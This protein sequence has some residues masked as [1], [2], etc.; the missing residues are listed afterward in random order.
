MSERPA[1]DATSGTSRTDEIRHI[2]ARLFYE[3]GYDAVGMRMI[4]EAAGVRPASLYHHFRSKEAMLHEIALEVTRD[5]ID[6]HLEILAS[7]DDYPGRLGRLVEL[8]VLYFWRHRYAM[9][10]G[11]REMR[12]LAPDH[13]AE[14]H[15]MRLRYQHAI[16]EFI[17]AG[18]ARGDFDC[19]DPHLAALSLLDMVNGINGWFRDSGRLTIAEVASWYADM[20]VGRLLA[21]PPTT[22]E[23]TRPS[24]DD[25]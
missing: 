23:P 24:G 12:S 22:D 9:S 15:E 5:F 18:A 20:I 25:R 8:H 3:H 4:A 10:V 2:A 7:P 13:F 19:D 11:L 21:P 14:V 17:A 6:E 16:Q 1:P